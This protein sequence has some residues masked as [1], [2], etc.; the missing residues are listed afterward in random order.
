MSFE[1]DSDCTEIRFIL[2]SVSIA[3]G[4]RVIELKNLTRGREQ[5]IVPRAVATILTLVP[6]CV[7]VN[8]VLGRPVHLPEHFVSARGTKYQALGEQPSI[9]SV[10]TNEK[11]EA[12]VFHKTEGRKRTADAEP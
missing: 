5:V 1:S 9:S 2:S 12:K 6:F 3:A 8:S 11:G 4:L 7:L 10:Q